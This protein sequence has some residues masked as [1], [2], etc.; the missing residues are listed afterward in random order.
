MFKH[1][2]ELVTLSLIGMVTFGACD[3][4]EDPGDRDG[5]AAIRDAP[6]DWRF[7]D[8]ELEGV[9][10]DASS[11]PV[12][13]E[14]NDCTVFLTNTCLC[15]DDTYTTELGTCCCQHVYNPEGVFLVCE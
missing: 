14:A 6:A 3:D 5:S 9:G 13:T 4:S 12:C 8:A 11:V 15:G 7:D 10:T 2:P 1:R